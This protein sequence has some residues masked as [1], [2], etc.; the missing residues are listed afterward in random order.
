VVQTFTQILQSGQH[1]LGVIND[2]LDFSKIEAGHLDLVAEQIDV[3]GI[4]DDCASLFSAQVSDRGLTMRVE[5]DPRIPR[6]LVGD[7]IR[8]RQVLVNLLGNAVKFTAEGEVGVRAEWLSEVDSVVTVRFTVHDT[9][10]GMS[11]E[12][13]GRVFS[14]FAQADGSITRRFGG[15]GLGLSI[16]KRLVELMGSVITVASAPG[17]GATFSFSVDLPQVDPRAGASTMPGPAPIS[18]PTPVAPPMADTSSPAPEPQRI[19]RGDDLPE[20]DLATLRRL[21]QELAPMLARNVLGARRVVD[22]IE[23]L[24]EH[25]PLAESFRPVVESA[26]VLRF[27][28]AAAALETFQRALPPVSR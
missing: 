4:V 23:A 22:R 10:I 18:V 9:G 16:C 19:V 7:A 13:I 17:R 20:V 8:L 15:T 12:Q 3:A 6:A 5:V 11:A 24:V 21:A 27:R 1:L 26:R 28:D 25:T 2:V 14:P